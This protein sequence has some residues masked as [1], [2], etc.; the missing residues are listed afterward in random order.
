MRA[1]APSERPFPA[2]TAIHINT[3]LREAIAI[4]L[5]PAIVT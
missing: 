2:A 3:E 1:N 5:V 4:R